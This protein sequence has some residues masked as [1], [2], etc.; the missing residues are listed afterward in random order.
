MTA[1]RARRADEATLI[2]LVMKNDYVGLAN[3]TGFTVDEI[4]RQID[5]RDDQYDALD[6]DEGDDF[7][8]DKVDDYRPLGAL[9][10]VVG[11]RCHTARDALQAA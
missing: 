4:E 9:S 10:R 2:D 7:F 3:L 8:F 6:D 11:G 1:R 5:G